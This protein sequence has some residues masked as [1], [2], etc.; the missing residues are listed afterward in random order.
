M[1][2]NRLTAHFGATPPNT[3][4]LLTAAGRH[5]LALHL[6]DATVIRLQQALDSAMQDIFVL[7]LIP[8]GVLIVWLIVVVPDNAQAKR[9]RMRPMG[10]PRPVLA[11]LTPSTVG[12]AAGTYTNRSMHS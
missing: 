11:P 9:L 10:A 1:E 2:L 8:A 4:A 3:S 5:G 6:G 7:A 12:I